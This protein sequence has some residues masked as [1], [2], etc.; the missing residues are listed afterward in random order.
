MVA[1]EHGDGGKPQAHGMG[2]APHTRSSTEP[3]GARALASVSLCAGDG[4][5]EPPPQDSSPAESPRPAIHSA[6]RWL[7][8]KVADDA[9]PPAEPASEPVSEP[10]SELRASERNV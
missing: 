8:A 2:V 5:P 7:A 4:L 1:F 9:K 3:A 6:Q 10:S